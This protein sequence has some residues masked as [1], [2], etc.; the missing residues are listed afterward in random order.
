EDAM[1]KLQW[2]FLKASTPNEL[3]QPLNKP[4]NTKP[5]RRAEVTGD[6]RIYWHVEKEIMIFHDISDHKQ[7]K[8][9]KDS[10]K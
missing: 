9:Y 8:T 7:A 3:P 1:E 2:A 6:L 5:F 4:S 10:H